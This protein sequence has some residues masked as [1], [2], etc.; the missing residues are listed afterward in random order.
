MSRLLLL[1]SSNRT[2]FANH[3]TKLTSSSITEW[4]LCSFCVNLLF[5][6]ILAEEPLRQL[7][8]LKDPEIF[9]PIQMVSSQRK[10]SK[11]DFQ[12][13]EQQNLPVRVDTVENFNWNLARNFLLPNFLEVD[14]R[15]NRWIHRQQITQKANWQKVRNSEKCRLTFAL[16]RPVQYLADPGSWISCDSRGFGESVS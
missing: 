11:S 12:I 14:K 3:L 10:T 6:T 1:S 13:E 4:S 2:A 5:W 15:S 9:S 8:E 7:L 16:A